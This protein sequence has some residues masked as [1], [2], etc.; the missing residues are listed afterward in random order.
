MISV[1][2]SAVSISLYLYP[3]I[4]IA[5]IAI[6]LARARLIRVVPS[7]DPLFPYDISLIILSPDRALIL[8]MIRFPDH[9][10]SIRVSLPAH[11][12][13]RLRFTT[14]RSVGRTQG[15]LLISIAVP[16]PLLYLREAERNPANHSGSYPSTIGF[17]VGVYMVTLESI[18]VAG[19]ASPLQ[20]VSISDDSSQL[21]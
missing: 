15:S 10:T 13:L 7:V 2:G 18:G 1:P 6:S 4:S 3:Y 5:S 21:S 9:F 17:T 8:D 14:P 12:D 11:T 20:S 16:V 19:V